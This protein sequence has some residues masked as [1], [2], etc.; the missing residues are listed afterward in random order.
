MDYRFGHQ[1]QIRGEENFFIHFSPHNFLTLQT[2]ICYVSGIHFFRR[3]TLLLRNQFLHSFFNADTV[4]SLALLSKKLFLAQK[5]FPLK[6]EKDLFV[7]L[8]GNMTQKEGR[9]IFHLVVNSLNA[10]H[11]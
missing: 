6:K 5:L 8:K 10:L 11:S 4:Q 9:Q 2:L 1:S 3:L 7:C